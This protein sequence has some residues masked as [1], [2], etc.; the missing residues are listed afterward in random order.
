AQGRPYEGAPMVDHP[1]YREEWVNEPA[2]RAIWAPLIHPRHPGNKIYHEFPE[3]RA[4]RYWTGMTP[5]QLAALIET[6]PWEREQGYNARPRHQWFL[7][8]ADAFPEVTFHGFTRERG[9]WSIVVEGF[10][11]IAPAERVLES[12]RWVWHS[13]AGTEFSPGD[14][15]HLH[16]IGDPDHAW[17]ERASYETGEDTHCP[18]DAGRWHHWRWWD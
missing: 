13:L 11:L 16:R 14:E 17:E 18:E 2:V 3:L 1:L 8:L 5:A 15:R 9:Q 6:A 7:D 12:V 10:D 4:P